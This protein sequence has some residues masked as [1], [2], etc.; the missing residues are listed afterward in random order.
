M[1]PTELSWSHINFWMNLLTLAVVPIG[2]AIW[3]AL[4]RLREND[5]KHLDQRFD[6]LELGQQRIEAKLDT[7][8][9]WHLEHPK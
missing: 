2:L 5:L 3:R 7:H 8:I 6:K 9:S 1:P 4:V